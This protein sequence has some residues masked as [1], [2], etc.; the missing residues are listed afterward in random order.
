MSAKCQETIQN[1]VQGIHGEIRTTSGNQLDCT[2]KRNSR[3]KLR[4]ENHNRCAIGIK[5]KCSIDKKNINIKTN[6]SR[7]LEY[8]DSIFLDGRNQKG[9]DDNEIELDLVPVGSGSDKI[10]TEI[11]VHE[12]VNTASPDVCK[13]I[14]VDV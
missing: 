2:V 9:P 10:E 3:Y 13:T 8:E 12:I 6:K 5:I 7:K 1:Q 11:T 14:N 4:I